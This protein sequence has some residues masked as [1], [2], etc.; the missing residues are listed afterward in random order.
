MNL[1]VKMVRVWCCVILISIPVH[2]Q[3]DPEYL[4]LPLEEL[5]I[6]LQYLYVKNPECPNKLYVAVETGQALPADVI[7]YLSKDQKLKPLSALFKKNL[8]QKQVCKKLFL[9]FCKEYAISDW[10]EKIFNADFRNGWRIFTCVFEEESLAPE[11]RVFLGTRKEGK[12]VLSLFN[13]QGLIDERFET[14]FLARATERLQE[15]VQERLQ[16]VFAT[17]TQKE[18]DLC[19]MVQH[20]QPLSTELLMFLTDTQEGRELLC[21][22]DHQGQMESCF[23]EKYLIVANRLLQTKFASCLAEH[24]AEKGRKFA[25]VV[26]DMGKQAGCTSP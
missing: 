19:S 2:L 12:H 5:Q 8:H 3:A 22:F 6:L 25:Q 23:R 10:L 13:A 14:I 7:E 20:K 9:Y 21:L 4:S 18:W 24:Q 11:L 15:S 26:K 17:D 16:K 1:I